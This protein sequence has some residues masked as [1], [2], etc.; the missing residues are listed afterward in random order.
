MPDKAD[1]RRWAEN[2]LY[3]LARMDADYNDVDGEVQEQLKELDTILDAYEKGAE[4]KPAPDRVEEYLKV[5]TYEKFMAMLE[6]AW[7]TDY[8]AYRVTPCQDHTELEIHTGG[9]SENEEVLPQLKNTFYWG[10]AW[11][12]SERGGHYYLKVISFEKEEER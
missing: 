6:E 9:W 11:L 5:D 1:I 2:A 7:D 3:M 8:G 10:L 12:R 4:D